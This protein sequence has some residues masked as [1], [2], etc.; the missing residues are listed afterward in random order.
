MHPAHKRLGRK[1]YALSDRPI[2][3]HTDL[4]A[5]RHTLRGDLARLQTSAQRA[6]ASFAT[7]VELVS[8]QYHPLEVLDT[9]ECRCH[10]AKLTSVAE[11]D[12]T[13]VSQG[14]AGAHLFPRGSAP[15]ADS[16]VPYLSFESWPGEAKK[17]C[18]SQCA[19][20]RSSA[21]LAGRGRLLFNLQGA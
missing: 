3:E 13:A 17:T 14:D 7:F 1:R 19:D 6:H 11:P 9:Y 20:A 18:E 8:R 15:K 12:A 16:H 5:L 2:D 4:R 10:V 21:G